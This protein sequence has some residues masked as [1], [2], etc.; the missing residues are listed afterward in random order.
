MDG[1][2]PRVMAARGLI[3]SGIASPKDVDLVTAA[4]RTEGVMQ[5]GKLTSLIWSREEG[6]RYAKVTTVLHADQEQEAIGLLKAAVADRSGA[7]PAAKVEAAIGRSPFDFTTPHGMKQREIIMA[8]ASAGR[9]TVGIGVAGS[10]KTVLAAPIV[11]A[12]HADGWQSVGVTLAWRQT[13]GLKQAG[14]GRQPD[15]DRLL[16]AGIG[17]DRAFALH[18][19]LKRAAEGKIDPNKKTLVVVDEIATIGTRQILDLAR[20]Q[21]QYGFKIVG[22]GD[23]RQ[24]HSIEAGATIDLFRRAL[25]NDQVPE[26]LETVRQKRLDDREIAKLFR[27][28]DAAEALERMDEAG[29]LHLTPGSYSDAI[30]AGVDEWERRTQANRG[31][32]SYTIGISVPTNADAQAVGMEMRR[33]QPLGQQWTIKASDQTGNTYDLQLAVGDQ[34]R[35]FNRVNARYGEQSRGY[36]GENGT[37]AKVLAIGEKAI[38]LQRADGRTG[39]LAW[40]SLTPKDSDRVRLAYGYALTI[41]ARQ[42]DTLTDHFTILPNGTRGID[43]HKIYPADTRNREDSVLI[44]S[45]GAEK[46]ALRDRQP[47]G[48][49]MP[50]GDQVKPAIMENMARSLSRQ[51]GPGLAVDSLD[52]AMKVFRGSVNAHQAAWHRNTVVMHDERSPG[53]ANHFQMQN[54]TG[55][56]LSLPE[57]AKV[58][59]IAFIY[60][61]I[62]FLE[63]TRIDPDLGE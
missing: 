11:D 31:R 46:E 26:I 9:A 42:G 47:I 34:V 35:L 27:N 44:V 32:D 2:T 17:Q 59:S 28:G 50:E 41:D 12:Y 15:T 38:T 23:D 39:E 13:H 62:E 43:A 33:R 5:N 48:T 37:T 29:L 6:R 63:E 58:S 3:R 54:E 4:Y 56:L 61:F 19:F 1:A 55:A 14:V 16:A 21:A 24:A 20:L 8:L 51:A 7:L 22:L 52:G 53:L 49:P 40:T 60:K 57:A 25:G 30:K 18:P 10:G 45:H 36:F